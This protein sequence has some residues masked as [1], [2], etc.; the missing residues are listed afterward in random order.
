MSE[1]DL[2]NSHWDKRRIIIGCVSIV[3]LLFIGL[4]AKAYFLDAQKGA[5]TSKNKPIK[6]NVQGVHSVDEDLLKSSE[7]EDPTPTPIVV[8]NIVQ[9]KLDSIKKQIANLSPQDVASSSPQVQKVLNDIQSLEQY[10]KNQAREV[11]QKICSSF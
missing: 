1:T 11:C 8:S 5:S 2:Q 10:P 9:Q 4:T 3:S 7:S 6:T